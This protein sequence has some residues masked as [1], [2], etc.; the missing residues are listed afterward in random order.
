MSVN[1]NDIKSQFASLKYE[2]LLSDK[3]FIETCFSKKYESKS[4]KERLED[5]RFGIK[6][7]CQPEKMSTFSLGI[8][9]YCEE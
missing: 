9:E 1:A 3:Y 2:Q 5:L 7:L 4:S 6:R 8:D